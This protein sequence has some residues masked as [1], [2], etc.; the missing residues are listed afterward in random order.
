MKVAFAEVGHSPLITTPARHNAP[1]G[2]KVLVDMMSLIDWIDYG[3]VTIDWT[4][5]GVTPVL[6]VEASKMF[7]HGSITMEPWP[8]DIEEAFGQDNM[9]NG[10]L[11]DIVYHV[12]EAIRDAMLQAQESNTI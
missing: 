4:G 8:I 2:A 10:I 9:T 12:E 3:R 1:Q 11:Q 5:D 6:I 7:P